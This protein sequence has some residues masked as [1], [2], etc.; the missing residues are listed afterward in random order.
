M[1][2]HEKIINWYIQR[3]VK[4]DQKN[5]M[6]GK[7]FLERLLDKPLEEVKAININ[8]NQILIDAGHELN[9]TPRINRRTFA[10]QLVSACRQYFLGTPD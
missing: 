5:P 2:N 6:H 3:E 9:L 10:M 4:A 1:Q 8:I 7:I